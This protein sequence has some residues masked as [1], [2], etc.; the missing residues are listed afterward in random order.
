MGASFK[1]SAFFSIWECSG[2]KSKTHPAPASIIAAAHLSV[3]ENGLGPVE[4]QQTHVAVSQAEVALQYLQHVDARPH[5][6]HR[7]A[8]ERVQPGQQVVGRHGV[9]AEGKGETARGVGEGW[10]RD[11]ETE[12]RLGISAEVFRQ[13]IKSFTLG[14]FFLY[15]SLRISQPSQDVTHHKIHSVLKS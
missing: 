15:I 12:R 2:L 3:F 1:S 4:K 13:A 5:G 14:C 8:A 7:V 6:Q 10:G 9:I 11:K